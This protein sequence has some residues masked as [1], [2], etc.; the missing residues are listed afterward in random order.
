MN[1]ARIVNE[2]EYQAKRNEILDVALRL[3]YSKG[4]AQMT[5]QDIL[6]G[7]QISRGALYH[8]FDSKQAILEALVDRMCQEAE[9]TVLPIAEN[10]NLSAIQKLNLYFERSNRWKSM[11]KELIISLMRMWY[12]DENVLIRQKMSYQSIKHTARLL[13]P[14]ILQGIEE[15]VFTTRFPEQAAVIFSGVA[16]SILDSIIEL[17]ISPK[18]N[19]GAFQKLEIIM[20]AYADA[21]ERILGAPS[22]SLTVFK[23]DTFE[24]WFNA[25]DSMPN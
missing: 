9:Q 16:L 8:Y 4:Y 18:P 5:I 17:A 10:P 24:E 6:N 1:M 19:Q 2:R 13:E 14:V 11:Q 25:I 12:T 21:I 15:K 20:D 7:L 22:G 3:I 23:K